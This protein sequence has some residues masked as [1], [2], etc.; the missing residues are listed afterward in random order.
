M[1][2]DC[3]AARQITADVVSTGDQAD[4]DQDDEADDTQASTAKAA[5]TGGTAP[6][7]NIAT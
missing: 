4:D 2:R 6:I 5:S 3:A 7:F 1:R